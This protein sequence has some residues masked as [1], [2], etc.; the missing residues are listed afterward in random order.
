MPNLH[1]YCVL[2]ISSESGNKLNKVVVV[3]GWDVV[4]VG[5]FLVVVCRDIIIVSRKNISKKLKV[6]LNFFLLGALQL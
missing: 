5:R 4:V 2:S 1:L 6:L 3:V